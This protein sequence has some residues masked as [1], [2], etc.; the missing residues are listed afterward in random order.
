ML[1]SA[2]GSAFVRCIPGLDDIVAA[3][4]L[5]DAGKYRRVT[6]HL[7]PRVL[8]NTAA[9]YV[10]I[11]NQL[12]GPNLSSASACAAGSQATDSPPACVCVCAC[13]CVCVRACVYLSGCLFVQEW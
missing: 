1:G 13:G 6:P 3:G 5:L 4:Q 2:N 9:G 12:C 10:S 11:Q 7:V 8:A